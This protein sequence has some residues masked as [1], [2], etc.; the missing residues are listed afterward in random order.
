[1]S[2][3]FVPGRGCRSELWSSTGVG[4]TSRYVGLGLVVSSCFAELEDVDAVVRRNS[5]AAVGSFQH[6]LSSIIGGSSVELQVLAAVD[7]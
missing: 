3:A 7:Q 4:C 6:P 2:C 5:T 1:M